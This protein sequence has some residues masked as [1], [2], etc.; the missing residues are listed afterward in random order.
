MP[1]ATSVTTASAA[2]VL[3]V[4]T[5]PGNLLICWAVIWNPTRTLRS[6]FNYLV[7]NLAIVDLIVEAVTEPTFVGAHITEALKHKNPKGVRRI[8]YIS[9][10]MSSIASVLSIVVLAV[11]RYRTATSNPAHPTV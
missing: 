1:F 7:L 4:T 10:F 8:V 3:S 5:V 2:T 6:P 9:Y 11:S